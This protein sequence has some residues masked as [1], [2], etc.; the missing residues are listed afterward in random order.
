MSSFI[1]LH[2][3]I[4]DHDIL[5]NDNNAFLVFTKILLRVNWETG[6]FITGRFKLAEI[7]NLNPNTL[8]KT[9]KRLSGNNMVTLES[10]NRSTKI[11]VTNWNKFQFGNNESNSDVTTGEQPGNTINK[12]KRN[13]NKESN[14]TNRIITK[15]ITTIAEATEEELEMK[16]L[17]KE[18]TNTSIRTDIPENLRAYRFLKKE[19]GDSLPDFLKASRWI[20]SD[21]YQPRSL[22]AKMTSYYGIR[23]KLPLVESYMQSQ[24]DK[25]VISFTKVTNIPGRKI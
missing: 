18:Y 14:N 2:R 23:E 20:R 4:L 7:T 11:T 9:L 12:N 13:K 16:S 5:A 21:S 22:Q 3:S 24:V 8:Y 19:L 10:N 17:W 6:S 25:H 15:E 1:K